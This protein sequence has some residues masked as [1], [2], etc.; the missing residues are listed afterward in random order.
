MYSKFTV[1]LYT[2]F[3]CFNALAQRP[4]R[5]AFEDLRYEDHYT[6]KYGTSFARD[7]WTW[8]YTKEFADQYR[9]PAKWIEPDMTG[10]LAIAFRVTSAGQIDSC[11]LG[12]R[13]DNC[14]PTLACQFDIFYDNRIKLPWIAEIAVRDNLMAGLSSAAYMHHAYS[15]LLERYSAARGSKNYGEGVAI[16]LMSLGFS[17]A[18]GTFRSFPSR[19]LYYDREFAPN[20]G[21]IGISAGACPEYPYRSGAHWLDFFKNQ[22]AQAKSAKLPRNQLKAIGLMHE[23][24]IPA[25]YMKRVNAALESSTKTNEQTVDRLI[26][27]FK[28]K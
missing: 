11:G 20:T 2:I 4:E 25:N 7:P 6:F 3:L 22:A 15:P 8:A 21:L 27:E 5:P 1:F 17:E 18:A 9:M 13:E 19:F 10:I 28:K 14:W 26:R 24:F 12:G 16:V 23:A